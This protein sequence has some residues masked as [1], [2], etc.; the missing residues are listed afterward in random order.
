LF[1]G[2]FLF[3]PYHGKAVKAVLSGRPDI[4]K[5][6]KSSFCFHNL[7]YSGEIIT[8]SRNKFFYNAYQFLNK[9]LEHFRF[10]GTCKNDT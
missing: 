8:N 1:I 5:E 3:S 2:E 6:K 7:S 9:S 4:K 10:P